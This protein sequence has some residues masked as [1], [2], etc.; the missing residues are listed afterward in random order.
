[1][2]ASVSILVFL[3][4]GGL[5]EGH[6]A[7]AE[8]VD[9]ETRR[10]CIVDAAT[11][12]LTRVGPGQCDGAPQWSPDGAWLAFTTRAGDGMGIYVV[13]A[14]GSEGR[15]VSKMFVWNERPAWSPD[16]SKLAYAAAAD[17]NQPTR[18]VVYDRAG[19]TETVWG[20]EHE[21]LKEPAWVPSLDLM[22]ALD[23]DE[24]LSYEGLDIAQFLKEGH[25]EGVLVAAGLSGEPGKLSTDIFLFTHTQMVPLLVFLMPGGDRYAEWAPRPDQDAYRFAFESNDGGDREIFVLGRRGIGDVSNHREADWNPAWSPEDHYL[26]FESFRGGRRGVYGVYPETARVFTIAADPAFDC[27]APTWS[28]DEEW[29]A[30]VANPGPAPQIFLVRRDGTDA[31]ALTRDADA[32]FAPAWQPEDEK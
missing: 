32:A 9:Q 24:K 19:D 12:E 11:G 20:G 1:M 30:Y 3:A 29:L 6:I 5:P 17:M 26:S 10:V 27:W 28:P 15:I 31:R 8:G 13:R 25:E 14:D 23:P 16:G 22:R 18:A 21:G 4:A 7:F 2:I